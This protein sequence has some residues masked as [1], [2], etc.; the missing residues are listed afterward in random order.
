M[1]VL[2]LLL[3]KSLFRNLLLILIFFIISFLILFF[4][5]IYFNIKHFYLAYQWFSGKKDVYKFVIYPSKSLLWNFL[6]DENDDFSGFV[7]QLLNKYRLKNYKIIYRLNLPA[8]A[9]INLLWN[10]ILTDIFLFAI[11]DKN[12]DFFK[13]N[14]IDICLSKKFLMFYNSEISDWKIFPKLTNSLLKMLPVKL[15]IWKSSFFNTYS[16]FKVILTWNI[17]CFDQDIP[18]IGL[19]VRYTQIIDK[20]P[21]KYWKI[22][23]FVGYTSDLKLLNEIKTLA[24]NNGY[25]YADANDI[26]VTF[27]K[28]ML[29]YKIVGLIILYIVIFILIL[30]LIYILWSVFLIEKNI[31]QTIFVQFLSIKRIYLYFGLYTLFLAI[32]GYLMAL[33]WYEIFYNLLNKKINDTLI[34]YWI[35]YELLDISNFIKIGIL[36]ILVIGVGIVDTILIYFKK[37]KI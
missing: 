28:K 4:S 37:W 32:L 11:K 22:T 30:F 16:D 6:R 2:L 5:F 7:T 3:R 26:K 36:L 14:D 1:K 25:K 29:V 13:K 20:I 10:Q 24:F 17:D 15:I 9:E 33:I 18:L 23:K 27:E 19:W 31:W 8:S 21:S 34:Q 12:S 35:N